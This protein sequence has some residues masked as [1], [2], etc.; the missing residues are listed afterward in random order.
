MSVSEKDSGIVDTHTAALERVAATENTFIFVRPTEYDT[1]VLIRAGY[2]TKS[3][4]VH[5]KS[6]NWGPMAGFVP[7]DPAFSKKC[8]GLPNPNEHEHA[9]GKANPVQLTL[10]DSLLKVH[11]K[12]E[13]KDDVQLVSAP[14]AKGKPQWVARR[15]SGGT[16]V[17]DLKSKFEAFQS[18]GVPEYKFC[19]AKPTDFGN[20][21]TLFCLVRESGVEWSVYWV[22]WNGDTGILNPLRVFSYPQKG[23]KLNPVTG[24]YDLWMVS[25]HIKHLGAH[26]TTTLNTDAHGSSAASGYTTGLILKMNIA[27]ARQ[28]VPVFNH[29]AEAQN[30]GFTQ[31]LDVH[32]AMF[33]PGGTSRMVRMNQMP[34]ILADLQQ[35]GYLVVWNKRYSELDPRLMDKADTRKNLGTIRSELDS[36]FNE[37]DEIRRTANPKLVAQQTQATGKMP[38]AMQTELVKMAQRFEKSRELGFEQ[39]RIYRFNRQLLAFMESQLKSLRELK[40]SDFPAKFVMYENEMRRIHSSLQMALVNATTNKG[41]TNEAALRDWMEQNRIPL[42]NLKNYWKI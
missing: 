24:D 40:V 22:Q 42:E 23:G 30:Y 13:Y 8:E 34:G 7:C 6:S 18:Q 11:T 41:E 9:H 27:C 29:G 2:A 12:I 10:K 38:T 3:M 4:D 26:T 37:L 16:G 1:T 28:D 36:L 20:K 14:A 5:H 32:L 39:S 35:G 31:A 19:T 25:P 17:K 15:K 21:S 33:T